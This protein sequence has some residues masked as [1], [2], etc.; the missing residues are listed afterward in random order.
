MKAILG[1]KYPY[2]DARMG[3][4]VYVSLLENDRVS[5][6]HTKWEQAHNG[7]YQFQW[8]VDMQL[9]KTLKTM[10]DV[11]L[12]ITQVRFSRDIPL[13]QRKEVLKSMRY[14]LVLPPEAKERLLKEEKPKRKSVSVVRS[15]PDLFDVNASDDFFYGESPKHSPSP[16]SSNYSN[17]NANN[18]SNS[19]YANTSP[20][21]NQ[22][23][24]TSS[25][26]STP[27]ERNNNEKEVSPTT[28]TT[29]P[30]N[31][32]FLV[33]GTMPFKSRKLGRTQSSPNTSLS[34]YGKD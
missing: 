8:A 31:N 30:N 13:E 29:A 19:N 14:Y 32:G 9:D 27:S 18:N 22:D 12:Y 2:K 16:S 3:W 24:E 25:S 17:N 28:T 15:A 4:R 23:S 7:K 20:T 6:T 10:V 26:N 34:E 1:K 5:V 21:T 33:S 11:G